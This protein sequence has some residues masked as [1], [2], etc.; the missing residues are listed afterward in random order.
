MS[1]LSQW[2]GRWAPGIVAPW[3]MNIV[4]PGIY[5]RGMCSTK[6]SSY[7]VPNGAF[8]IGPE[9]TL[10]SLLHV[11]PTA[12]LNEWWNKSVATMVERW[13]A[14]V[15]SWLLQSKAHP[16]LVVRFEDV[17]ANPVRE[18]GRIL[19]FLGHPYTKDNLRKQLNG[20][21]EGFKRPHHDSFKHYTEEQNTF[22]QNTVE[23]TLQ[24]LREAN[25]EHAALLSDYLHTGTD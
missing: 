5:M 22:I 20:S 18:V 23:K 16:V 13:S 11:L 19:K 8:C 3:S 9:Y 7:M 4:A 14:H 15:T 25:N 24:A 1:C 6:A 12:G 17:K 10:E 21:C 2:H